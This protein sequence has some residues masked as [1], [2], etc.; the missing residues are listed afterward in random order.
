[1]TYYSIDIT[2][3]NQSFEL[4][5]GHYYRSENMLQNIKKCYEVTIVSLIANRLEVGFTNEPI[6]RNFC[7]YYGNYS[8][9]ER[10]NRT[11]HFQTIIEKPNVGGELMVCIDSDDLKFYIIIDNKQQEFNITKLGNS[12]FW[13]VYLDSF[14]RER[15]TILLNLGHTTFSNA[16]PDGFSPWVIPSIQITCN[17]IKLR[18]MKFVLIFLVCIQKH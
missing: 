7:S 10:V 12:T 13:A 8:F 18:S 15:D 11:D 16:M 9:L 1:M 6:E 17:T 4:I 5:Y 2:K 3:K 14:G